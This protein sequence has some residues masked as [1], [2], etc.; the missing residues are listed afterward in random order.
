MPTITPTLLKRTLLTTRA[1]DATGG[2]AAATISTD[3]VDREHDVVLPSGGRL[4]NYRKNPVVL[5]GH[6]HFDVPVGRAISIDVEP[7]GL[8]AV[9]RWLQDDPF[10]VRVKN[11][12]DQDVLNA[13]SIGFRPLKWEPNEHG[14][15]TYTEWELLEF[16]IVPVPAN[17]DAVRALK[18]F[19]LDGPEVLART[20]ALCQQLATQLQAGDVLS[21]DQERRLH[22]ANAL[23]D[24]AR[25]RADEREPVLV[26]EDDTEPAQTILI[27]GREVP[28]TRA[29]LAQAV[30]Y[31]I[32]DEVLKTTGRLPDDEPLIFTR[33]DG[34]E[35][36]LVIGVDITEKELAGIL[37][38]ALND[39]L[40]RVTGRVD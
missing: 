28:L 1:P 2:E 20:Q 31:A 12:W 8:R 39:A 21:P 27:D 29:T 38:D 30:R 14:G 3:S 22:E 25:L 5:Y 16:S 11:A 35:P 9:W 23:L 37:K 19:G 36:T 32:D 17:Q 33:D 15:Y 13:V 40:M 10:A 24:A 4:A 6:N 18:R 26:L 34:S 7:T